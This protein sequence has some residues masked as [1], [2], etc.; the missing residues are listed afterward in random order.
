MS[1]VRSVQFAS[2]VVGLLALWGC[3]KP[4][5]PEFVSKPEPWRGS[6]E[7][8]CLTNNYVRSS[9]FVVQR[10]A[11]G[12]PGHCGAANPFE[13]SAA[14]GGQVQMRPPA[15]LIC[16][17]IA[18]VDH[19]TAKVVIPAARRHFGMP[20]VEI[21]VA[22]S[23]GCRPIN[24]VRGA[25]L[26]EHGHANALDV[27]GF[28]LADGRWVMV[29]SGWYGDL[30]ERAFLRHVHQ[31]SCDTFTTVLGPNYDRNHHDHF[32]L[33]LARQGRDGMVRICK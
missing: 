7:N 27:A 9:P 29:K 28:L 15:L 26:S 32:H 21:K 13:M 3:S 23:Y 17:M 1:W 22:A 18:S 16:P 31:G 6:E 11:L 12:G 4:S 5:S 8:Q 20:I 10:A 24:H 33:D 25:K 2:V 14:L 30:R 19:W